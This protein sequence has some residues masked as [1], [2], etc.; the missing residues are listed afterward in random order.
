MKLDTIKTESHCALEKDLGSQLE[1]I[2]MEENVENLEP[3]EIECSK[4][5]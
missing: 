5:Y 3:E 2:K 4:N 1:K